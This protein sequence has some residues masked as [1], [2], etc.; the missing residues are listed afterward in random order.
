MVVD[1]CLLLRPFVRI[2]VFVLKSPSVDVLLILR[3][4]FG[5]LVQVRYITMV[6]LKVDYFYVD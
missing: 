2:D 1:H 3:V 6:A 5:A 4:L